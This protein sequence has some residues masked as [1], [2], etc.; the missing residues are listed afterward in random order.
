[1]SDA[2]HIF[3]QARMSS[4]RLPGKVMMPFHGGESIL[5]IITRKLRKAFPE[6]KLVVCT[7]DL[8]SDEPI[9]EFC[10]QLKIECF[11]GSEK[12]VVFRFLKAA[13]KFHSTNIV[14]ICADNPFLDMPMLKQLVGFHNS[15]PDNDY[16]SF[17]NAAGIP[18]I[19]THWGLYG[20]IIS[21]RTLQK[22]FDST[23]LQLYREHVTNYAYTH[24]QE[25]K[26]AFLPMPEAMHH[27][28]D[29]RF[30]IDDIQDFNNLQQ[31]YQ[32]H[33]NNNYDILHTIKQVDH[34]A[35]QNTMI[36]N[37]KKYSK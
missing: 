3:L 34:T 15:N 8:E 17:Q 35:M 27:R 32:M 28:D 10:N 36:Q 31:V 24:P 4:S 16:W 2:L 5:S 14:R 6:L 9:L 18:A 19:K 7:S 29:M 37:I 33:V 1:M 21:S 13:E 26:C 25:F 30:T 23:D 20:E 12:D 22:I 11:A